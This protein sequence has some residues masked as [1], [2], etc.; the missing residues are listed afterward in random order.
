[1]IGQTLLLVEDD[2]RLASAL[3]AGL[4]TRGYHVMS[5]GTCQEALALAN[6]RK[7]DLLILDIL[8][9]DGTGWDL[10]QAFRR[11]PTGQGVP[12]V[13]TTA[14]QVSRAQVAAWG[15]Q[16]CLSKPFSIQTLAEAVSQA[17]G[18]PG[19]SKLPS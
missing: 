5:A 4:Q 2:S 10:L 7:V 1:V 15:L 12:V 6:Q 19:I 17:L 13:V 16:A 18:R 11:Q 14:T 8:L 9:P 3:T